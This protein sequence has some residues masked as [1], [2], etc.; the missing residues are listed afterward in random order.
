MKLI[1]NFT[2]H[3]RDETLPIDF[4]QWFILEDS[5]NKWFEGLTG[6]YDLK[7]Y[8]QVHRYHFFKQIKRKYLYKGSPKRNKKKVTQLLEEIPSLPYFESLVDLHNSYN[9]FSYWKEIIQKLKNNYP[10][11]LSNSDMF[12]HS[13]ID[14]YLNGDGYQESSKYCSQ[15][16][17]MRKTKNERNFTKYEL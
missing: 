6:N 4:T 2:Q 5:D 1:P 11:E 10:V 9:L 12:N 14:K 13:K 15:L 17:G 16:T 8:F 7:T 3:L